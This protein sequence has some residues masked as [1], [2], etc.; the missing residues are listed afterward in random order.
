MTHEQL[1]QV[2]ERKI[3]EG[4]QELRIDKQALALLRGNGAKAAGPRE[5]QHGP[6]VYGNGHHDG[7]KPKTIRT[8]GVKGFTS[9][10]VA[11]ILR[12]NTG[13][14][15]LKEIQAI[16]A[17]K[18]IHLSTSAIYSSFHDANLN[19]EKITRPENVQAKAYR[20]GETKG[21]GS[22]PKS[23]ALQGVTIQARHE[24]AKMLKANPEGLLAREMTERLRKAGIPI[25]DATVHNALRAL[26]PIKVNGGVSG[27]HSIR[28]ALPQ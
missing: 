16:L 13:G 24:I 12:E 11:E 4:E 3:A 27:S 2:I 21:P 19:L 26:K 23:R 18:H 10:T 1:I 6:I 5:L 7:K 9:A 28:Y 8:Q 14:L 22:N 20:L 15:T 17:K 25:T